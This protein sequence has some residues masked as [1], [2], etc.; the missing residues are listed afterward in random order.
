MTPRTVAVF[1]C[2]ACFTTPACTRYEGDQGVGLRVPSRDEFDAVDAVLEPHCGTL[3]CHGSPARNFRVYG[4]YGLRLNGRDVT[5]SPDTTEAEVTATYQAIVGVDPESLSAVFHDRGRDA[6][7]WL[8]MR[9]ARG[10][11]NHKGGSP[12]PSGTHGDRCL[13]AWISG[14]TDQTECSEDVFGPVP[15]D[16]GAW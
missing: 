12:L 13:L 5:G 4:V 1:A 16:G 2:L 10:V 14:S 8:V 11:E 3:D 7:R 6:Q 15:R 9:K